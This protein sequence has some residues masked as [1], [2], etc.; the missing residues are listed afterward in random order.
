MSAGNK[1]CLTLSG[2]RGVQVSIWKNRSRSGNDYF[3]A[4]I[5]RR[6]KPEGEQEWKT[7]D[8]L[9]ASDLPIVAALCNEAYVRLGIR[10]FGPGLMARA[11]FDAPATE[12]STDAPAEEPAF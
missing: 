9:M 3:S 12:E 2:D 1:P 8:S 10:E 6:Y 5:S 7:T 4:R 11:N